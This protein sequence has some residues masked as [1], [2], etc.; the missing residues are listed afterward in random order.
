[1]TTPA[2]IDLVALG[3]I[4]LGAGG[5]EAGRSERDRCLA[6]VLDEVADRPGARLLLLGDVLDFLAAGAPEAEAV[7]ADPVA[8]ALAT[9]DRI[10]DRHE[11][12]VGDLA[13]LLAAGRRV[14][15]VVG[16][17]DVELSRPAVEAGLREV[18]AVRGAGSAAAAGGG[19]HIHR[20]IF[21]IPGV[22]YAEHGNQYH[23]IN[24]FDT[25]LTPYDGEGRTAH[26]LVVRMATHASRHRRSER[27][28]IATLAAV[29]GEAVG[30]A[31]GVADRGRRGRR[32]VYRREALAGYAPAVGISHTALV[33]IDRLAEV[34]LAPMAL[35]VARVA[36]A[37]LW[38][39]RDAGRAADGYLVRAAGAVHAL[40]ASRGESVPCYLFGHTHAAAEVPLGP[41]ESANPAGYLNAGGWIGRP[42]GGLHI[43]RVTRDGAG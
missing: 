26:P 9:L 23:D 15:L 33:G 40:L 28:R 14:D 21:H 41:S 16:N 13:R 5:P 20:W 32:A 8:D 11:D 35:R 27:G 6:A 7:S 2:P 30:E 17:H 31:V 37:S 4:H 18:L 3:D 22:L 19:L 25:F 42:A 1:M 34:R 43:V 10:A 36:L 29:A 24:S 39:S 38:R 12:T